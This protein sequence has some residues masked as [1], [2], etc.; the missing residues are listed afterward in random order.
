[1]NYLMSKLSLKRKSNA[2]ILL[3]DRGNK[4]FLNFP[5]S[6]CLN[7]NLIARVDFELA[8]LSQSSTLVPTPQRLT[9]WYPGSLPGI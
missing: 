4:D 2:T 1:M 7:M 8:M 6:Y 5:K 9:E 3:T